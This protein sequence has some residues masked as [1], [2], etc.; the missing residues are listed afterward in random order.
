MVI[1]WGS[2]L[3]IVSSSDL[4]ES[5][6]LSQ[7]N[8]LEVCN[9]GI[10][11]SGDLRGDLGTRGLVLRGWGI[12]DAR[13]SLERLLGLNAVISVDMVLM[14]MDIISTVSILVSIMAG[15]S[16][17]DLSGSGDRSGKGAQRC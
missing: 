9:S 10:V 14:I 4:R 13:V 17:G 5:L 7:Q 15:S 16:V 11:G 1:E 2:N 12:G 6:L 3:L 8:V